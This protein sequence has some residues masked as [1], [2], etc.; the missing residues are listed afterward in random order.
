MKIGRSNSRDYD[1]DGEYRVRRLPNNNTH[2]HSRN[3]SRDLD[4]DFRQRLTHSRTNSRDAN[5][6]FI[7]NFI[8]PDHPGRAYM[9]S[10]SVTSPAGNEPSKNVKKH[11]R[12]HSYDQI[13][14][15]PNNIQ[16]DQELHNKLFKN[17]NKTPAVVIENEL[18]LAKNTNSTVNNSNLNNSNVKKDFLDNNK[19]I[20]KSVD[21]ALA[22]TSSASGVASTSG[23]NSA[24]VAG[25][26]SHHSRNNSKDLNKASFLASLVDD[27]A[28][29][30]LRHRRTNSKET[31]RMGNLVSPSTSTALI[32]SSNI[33]IHNP[34]NAR[35]P[36]HQ[37]QQHS[38]NSSQ[39]KNQIAYDAP[40]AAQVLLSL[41]RQTNNNAN[42][43]DTSDNEFMEN[44]E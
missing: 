20:N 18:N 38:R 37:Q 4:S 17:R 2:T 25:G 5:I 11:S 27:A 12:N 1:K 9:T 19:F 43:F 15:K 3:N 44:N 8:K 30:L 14:N 7:L 39:S 10:T 35:P 13:Y 24:D 33:N 21:G 29:H 28:K 22:S 16:I 31:N 23:Y 34:T 40:D 26:P 36:P 41:S 42:N 6:K 32:D